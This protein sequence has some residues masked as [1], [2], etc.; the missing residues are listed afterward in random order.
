MTSS[1]AIKASNVGKCYQLYSRPVDRLKQSL[2]RGRRQ[3]YREFWALRRVSFDIRKNERIGVI[4]ANGSGK[5]TLLQ[6]ISSILR[7]TEGEL[8]ING[9][10]T[11]LLELGA[12]F[13]PEFT[14]RENVYLNG[15]I[16]GLG[17]AEIDDRYQDIAAFADIGDFLDQPVKTYSSGMYLRLAFAVAVNVSPDILL[18]DEALSVGDAR[19][20][21]KCMARIRNFCESGTVLFVSHDMGAI[22]ELCTRVIW[23]D[24]G[25]IRLDTTPKR[26]VEKYLEYMYEKNDGKGNEAARRA[27]EENGSQSLAAGSR[28]FDWEGFAPVHRDARQ[29][30]DRRMTIE[31][32]R[33]LSPGGV[34][35]G[36]CGDQRCELS[37]LIHAQVDIARPLVGFII[38]DRLGREVFADRNILI[39]FAAGKRYRVTF[40]IPAWPHLAEGDY[41]LTLGAADGTVEEHEQCHFVHEALIVHSMPERH[42]KVGIFSLPDIEISCSEI[43][44]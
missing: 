7:P 28:A 43:K 35:C 4:G 42:C 39:P 34:N 13:N 23:I 14:G 17:K 5:S 27:S 8:M 32:L 9:R 30:G 21:Q 16:M 11:A 29:F 37:V 6:I 41:S 33:F 36:I 22:T 31:M 3:Y 18:V 20:Q 19:F 40:E 25:G 10:V 44:D 15:A 1:I 26:A 38:K 2:W 24:Q 12:G